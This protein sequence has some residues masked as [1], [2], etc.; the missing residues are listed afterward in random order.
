MLR[1]V[2]KVTSKGAA[3]Y[4]KFRSII[5]I[6]SVWFFNAHNA[7]EYETYKIRT[8][9]RT[10]QQKNIKAEEQKYRRTDKQKNEGAKDHRNTR[11]TQQ[12]N[13]K[14]KIPRNRRTEKQKNR[15]TDEQKKE[16]QTNRKTG[17]QRNRNKGELNN[18][19]SK[20]YQNITIAEPHSNHLGRL[21]NENEF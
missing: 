15:K 10:E 8:H 1:A 17:E 19:R 21:K 6:F 12:M 16:G 5:C 3:T 20:I 11:T 7:A 14:T 9:R 2:M 13:R 4:I 18:R